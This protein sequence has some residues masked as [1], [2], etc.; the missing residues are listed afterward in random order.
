MCAENLPLFR[1]NLG[2]HNKNY[3]IKISEWIKRS[4]NRGLHELINP[5]EQVTDAAS[6]AE[7]G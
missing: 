6:G 7:A 1:G 3:A 5:D 4:Q 2:V